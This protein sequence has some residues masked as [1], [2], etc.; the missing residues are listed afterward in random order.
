MPRTGREYYQTPPLINAD[1][2]DIDVKDTRDKENPKDKPNQAKEKQEAEDQLDAVE[3]GN[4]KDI[5]KAINLSDNPSQQQRLQNKLDKLELKKGFKAE[6]KKQK[7]LESITKKEFKP[8][9]KEYTKAKLEKEASQVPNRPIKKLEELPEPK[10]LKTGKM[11][12]QQAKSNEKMSGI[13]KNLGY[14]LNK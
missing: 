9:Y 13:A 8:K 5:R 12:G 14:F 4:F 11:S 7:G 3:G 6:K 2:G 1:G 10:A